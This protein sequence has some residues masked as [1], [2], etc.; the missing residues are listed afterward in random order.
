MLDLLEIKKGGTALGV[1]S[2]T[3]RKAASAPAKSFLR[4]NSRGLVEALAQLAVRSAFSGRVQQLINM[5]GLFKTL[6]AEH[7][8]VTGDQAR[9]DAFVGVAGQE[10]AGAEVFVQALHAGGEVDVLAE[11]GVIHAGGAAE[12]ADV[13]LAGVQADAGDNFLPSVNSCLSWSRKRRAAWHAR[14]GWFSWGFGGVPEGE[15]GVAN[16]LD[17]GAVGVMDAVVHGAL[18]I[19]VHQLGQFVG[20]H[21]LG[22]AGEAGDVAEENGKMLLL[23]A[24]LEQGGVA[25]EFLHQPGREIKGERL[26]DLL[27]FHVRFGRC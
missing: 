18:E 15:D 23:R 12:I 27:L 19:G 20:V 11:G 26:F 14:K 1:V 10:D 8:Q 5:D 25:G 4:N 3:R 21:A 16:I 9:A 13:G 22:N 24:R 7:T 2:R 17:N 6:Q